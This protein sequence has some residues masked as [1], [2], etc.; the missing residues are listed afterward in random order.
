[1][2]DPVLLVLIGKLSVT[3]CT[4]VEITLRGVDEAVTAHRTSVGV[5]F[6]PSLLAG[7]NHSSA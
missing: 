6:S 2:L 3:T 1:M 7:R 4:T 5:P